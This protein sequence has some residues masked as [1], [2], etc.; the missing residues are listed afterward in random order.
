MQ[1]SEREWNKRYVTIC[2]HDWVHKIQLKGNPELLVIFLKKK[3]F[4]FNTT[5]A[6]CTRPYVRSRG[7]GCTPYDGLYPRGVLGISSDGD[8]RMERKVKTQKNP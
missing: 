5:C 3:I 8:D 1:L 7:E 6:G 4:S 2:T